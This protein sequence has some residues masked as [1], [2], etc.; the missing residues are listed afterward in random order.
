MPYTHTRFNL[1]HILPTC[2]AG[3]ESIPFKVCAVRSDGAV[4]EPGV[5]IEQGEVYI[6]LA[7]LDLFYALLGFSLT[8]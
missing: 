8:V 1:I 4:V 6:D 2:S 3:T 7:I 5:R